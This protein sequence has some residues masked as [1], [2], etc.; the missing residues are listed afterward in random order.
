MRQE[1]ITGKA[2]DSSTN[3]IKGELIVI[4]SDLRLDL[5]SN[6]RLNLESDLRSTL[7]ED[8]HF[9]ITVFLCRICIS[10]SWLLIL[11]KKD[12]LNLDTN[13]VFVC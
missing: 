13:S 2:I 4:R 5:R 3:W 1:M 8:S 11:T 10:L 7:R 9:K 12:V 6:L